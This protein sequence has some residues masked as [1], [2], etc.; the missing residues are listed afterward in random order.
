MCSLTTNDLRIRQSYAYAVARIR[1]KENDLLDRA[2]IA[3]LLDASGISEVLRILGETEYSSAIEDL[4]ADDYETV[5]TNELARVF[6]FVSEFV[7]DLSV[8]ELFRLP[9]DLHNCKVAFRAQA[10][11]MDA[12]DLWSP[13]GTVS[14]AKIRR[15]VA[16]EMSVGELPE[17]VANILA[18]GFEH[19]GISPVTP[20]LDKDSDSGRLDCGSLDPKTLD[21]VLDRACFAGLREIVRK[22]GSSSIHRLFKVRVDLANMTGF[23]RCKRLK[24]S[25]GFFKMAFVPFGDLPIDAFEE[26]YEEDVET[27][28][29]NMS[30][31]EYGSLV[32]E[33]SPFSERRDSIAFLERAGRRYLTEL[34]RRASQSVFFG[35]EPIVNYLIAKENEVSDLRAIMVGKANGLDVQSIRERLSGLYE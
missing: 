27:F 21:M 6:A 29:R 10:L 16:G 26:V 4:S 22:T 24:R 14:A 31:S 3:R 15:A 17:H 18:A 9:Y 20:P 13:L 30:S 35:P 11:S 33:W 32:S 5:L 2:R 23:L 19:L 8:V 25:F 12:S 7:P 28:V 1:Q 34:S